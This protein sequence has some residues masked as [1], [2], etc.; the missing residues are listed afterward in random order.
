M[1]FW[2]LLAILGWQHALAADITEGPDA[3]ISIHKQGPYSSARSC[4]AKCLRYN[5][6]FGCNNA[7][8]NDLG[9]T[10]GCGCGPSNNCYC[11]TKFASS[12]TSYVVECVSTNC[13][14]DD[15]AQEA[16]TM[17][18]IYG[19]Y[20]ATANVA[21]STPGFSFGQTT[22]AKPTEDAAPIPTEQTN[23][24][25][26]TKTGS[27]GAASTSETTATSDGDGEKKEGLSQSDIVAL[28]ASLGVGIPSLLV[29]IITLVVQMR[30]KKRRA[31]EQGA[32][33][34]LTAATASN[35]HLIH[36]HTNTP[37]PVVPAHQFQ[38]PP[39]QQLYTNTTTWSHELDAPKEGRERSV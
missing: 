21:V 23:P 26:G 36:L 29:A 13:D 2:L 11:S 34:P 10:L 17:L 4:A 30:K 37:T 25:R 24:T 7:G 39:I 5:G 33:S 20:C 1:I 12:A 6:D 16:S 35:V 27:H 22:T 9:R 18:Q 28:A 19:D 38:T 31:A 14:I 3:Y 8:F 32:S 15:W